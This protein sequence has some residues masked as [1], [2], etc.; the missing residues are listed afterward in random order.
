MIAAAVF[1]LPARGYAVSG[2]K[3]RKY[4]QMDTEK[5]KD[6]ETLTD[7]ERRV[8]SVMR[9]IEYGE[10]RVVI[11]GGKPVRIEEVRKSVRL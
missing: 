8:L 4:L 10:I 6:R 11:N 9:E 3:E 7:P 1:Y 5:N 2:E